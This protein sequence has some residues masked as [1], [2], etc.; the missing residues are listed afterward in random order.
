M[1]KSNPITTRPRAVLLASVALA[2]ALNLWATR[3]Q[4]FFEDEWARF[5]FYDNSL[6]SLLQGYT[7]H[8]VVLHT[9]LYKALFGLGG[10]YLQFRIVEA[11]LLGVCGLL[12]YAFARSRAQPWPCVAATTVLLFLG[13]AFEVTA[14]PYGI[15][16]L[17]PVAIGLAALVCLDRLRG[18]ADP[19]TC[20]LLVAAVA[21]HSNGLA[22]VV[23]AGVMLILQNGR[24]WW[25][26][27]WVVAVPVLSYATWLAWY[28]LAGYHTQQSNLG[29]V[30]STVV[31]TAAAGL[32]ATSGLFGNSGV[33]SG[34]FNIEAGYLL[35]GLLL[36][37]AIWRHRS[38]LSIAREILVPLAMGLA[39]WALLGTDRTGQ[40]LP[41][42]SRYIYTSAIFLLLI[43][44]ELTRGIRATPRVV[45]LTI[46]ALIVSLIPNLINLRERAHQIRG[47][48][49]LER[50][51]LGAL[52]LLRREVP[53]T[54]LPDLVRT[55]VL[56]LSPGLV[57]GQGFRSPERLA[58]ATYFAAVRENG[59]RV[60]TPNDL[61]TA[62]E[63]Q[64]RAIDK[65]LLKGGD[66]T[67]SHAPGLAS[68][69]RPPD[70]PSSI[71]PQ[72]PLRVPL[73][74]LVILPQRSRSEVT[75]LAR[76]F[77]TRF[78][79]LEVPARSGP[80]VL[81]PGSAE[82]VRPWFVVVKGATACQV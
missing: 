49:A 25:A 73:S 41:T 70:C 43:V 4:T 53:A 10:G 58:A 29:E 65:V 11:L 56:T 16:I 46:A 72:E 14:T 66:L 57:V 44:L 7:G 28:R 18:L 27:A 21:A 40:H 30:P 23:G 6:E 79:Q 38:G 61:L 54:S 17:L 52:E 47:F 26:R 75:V 63:A 82:L 42:T 33:R 68:D 69:R 35:L 39:F 62:T 76:R 60:A 19:L 71:D 36:A 50:A 31:A 51:D 81:R 59:S 9:L 15:V 48:A 64:Q 74:G 37:A 80:L 13:S 32:S 2:V 1:G 34:M 78:Q 3:G 22:F 55:R 24:R 45:W 8:L 12:F 20:L 77:S 67:L 5:L